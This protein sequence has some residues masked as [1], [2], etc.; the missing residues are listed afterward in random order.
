MMGYYRQPELTAEVI[1]KDGWFHSGD[2]GKFNEHGLLMITG[3]IKNIFKTSFGKYINP[4]FIE[5]K[6][7]LSGFIEQI[8]VL[9]ENQKYAAALIRPDFTFLKEWCRRHEIPYTTNEEMIH[10]PDV[11]KRYGKEVKKLNSGLG[12]VEKIKKFE[13]VAD[14]WSV[15]TGILTPT[16]KIKR[17]VVMERYS[18][19]IDS[20]F[21]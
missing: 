4:D 5:S 1:D 12:E 9:G 15:S 6:F 14:E 3:R 10:N 2:L 8:V 18:D 11:F 13:L 7:V 19:L 21:A 20:L 17:K 16:L